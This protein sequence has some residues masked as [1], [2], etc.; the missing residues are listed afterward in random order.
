MI[1]IYTDRE[2]QLMLETV[3]NKNIDFNISAFFKTALSEHLG[4]N[5][6]EKQLMNKIQT[7][8]MKKDQVESELTF[9]DGQM[10]KL[11]VTEE[12]KKQEEERILREEQEAERYKSYLES[13]SKFV[14]ENTEEYKQGI[15][16]GKWISNTDFYDKKKREVT[17]GNN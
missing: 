11:K 15:K 12:Y 6:E 14:L 10:Q 13:V 5:V 4:G 3:K 9:L 2:T 7:A 8:R 1:S 16:E 17:H